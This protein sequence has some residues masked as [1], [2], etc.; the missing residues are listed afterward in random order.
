MH[1]TKITIGKFDI[2][3]S[4]SHITDY[5]G[6]KIYIENEIEY[7]IYLNVFNKNYNWKYFMRYNPILQNCFHASLLNF[8]VVCRPYGCKNKF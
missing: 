7:S 2:I 6:V 4:Y 1:S 5:I 3:V 8:C